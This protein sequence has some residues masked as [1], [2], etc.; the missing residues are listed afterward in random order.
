MY[1]NDLNYRS[2]GNSESDARVCRRVGLCVNCSVWWETGKSLALRCC[3]PCA[4]PHTVVSATAG[5][6]PALRNHL[7]EIAVVTV[8]A[9]LLLAS[10]AA[11]S[12]YRSLAFNVISGTLASACETGQSRFTAFAISWN[13]VSSMPGTV[14]CV[15]K[16]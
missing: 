7:P 10:C 3:T 13:F 16:T 4:M 12:P 6:I 15:P 2:G 8:S 1:T 9:C 14:V 11:L 5:V